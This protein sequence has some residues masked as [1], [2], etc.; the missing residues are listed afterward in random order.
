MNEHGHDFGHEFV[1]EADWDMKTRFFG[2]SDT[3][4]D[5]GSVMT[6]DTGS[7]THTCPKTGHD[8]GHG[9]SHDTG[10]GHDFR[11]GHVRKPRTRTNFALACRLI[12]GAN[13]NYVGYNIRK[14]P[15]S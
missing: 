12:S 3:D 6:S 9:E 1:S 13:M 5:M 7:D 2:T 4:S 10:Q 8:F 14:M 15:N 11:H